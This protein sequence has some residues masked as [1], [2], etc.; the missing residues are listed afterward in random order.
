MYVIYALGLL[1]SFNYNQFQIHN[2]IYIYIVRNPT[3][4]NSTECSYLPANSLEDY[5]SQRT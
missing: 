4:L 5:P 3:H 2:R 1:K